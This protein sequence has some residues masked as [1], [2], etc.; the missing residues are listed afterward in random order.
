MTLRIENVLTGRGS[1]RPVPE[2]HKR[3]T[4]ET[5]ASRPRVPLADGAS[6]RWSAS[7]VYRAAAILVLNTLVLLAL[8]ELGATA[9]FKIKNFVVPAPEETLLIGEGSPRET[10]SY[11]RSQEWAPLL[12]QEFRLSRTRLQY[13]PYVGWRRPAFDGKLIRIDRDGIRFT[14]GADCRPGSYKVFAFGGSTMWG[15]GAPDWGTIPAYVQAGLAKLRSGPVC[16]VNFG[17]TAYVSTQGVLGLLMQLQAGN[18]PDLVLFYD[19]PNEIF[20]AYQSG[21]AGNPQNVDQLA[22]IFERRDRPHPLR[23][24]LQDSA[25]FALVNAVIL[26]TGIARPADKHGDE[27]TWKVTDVAAL[28]ESV[29]DRY[30]RNYMAV[31]ALAQQHHFDFLFFWQPFI[32][33]GQ[34][35]LTSEE[36][37]IRDKQDAETTYSE[38]V[39][40]VYRGIEA[41]APAH[42]NLYDMSHVLDG[43]DGLLW[44]DSAHVAPPGNELLAGKMVEVVEAR[45]LAS[46]SPERVSD[47]RGDVRRP[48]K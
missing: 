29:V 19:G 9:A 10:I 27:P 13:V 42:G 24:W 14:P 7:T 43:H 33:I 38:L 40:S 44:I 2:A 3:V 41:A 30:L 12:W 48:K 34:K 8:F 1:R 47:D 46:H 17:E 11:Y 32:S 18:V 6:P 4:G 5:A 22:A 39:R 45:S 16:V 21:R 31:S 25:S 15:T 23:A 28:S 20:A 26:R 37:E 35:P 36:R